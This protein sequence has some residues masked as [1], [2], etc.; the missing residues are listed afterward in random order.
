ML[1]IGITFLV[2][3]VTYYFISNRKYFSL[4]SPGLCLPV[5]GHVYKLMTEEGKKDPVMFLWNLYKKHQRN[6]MMHLRSFNLDLVF[7]GDFDTLKYI[8]NHPDCQ[9]RVIKAFEAPT[10]EDRMI[11]GKYIPGVIMSEGKIWADQRRFTLRTLRD[12]GF[13]KVGMEEMVLDEVNL[14]K[15]LIN[16]KKAE[17]IDFTNQFNL[18]ILNALWRI[19]VGDRF[20]YDNPKLI[21]IIERL[22]DMFKRI[23]KPENVITICFPWINKIF[24]TFLERDLSLKTNHDIMNLILESIKQHQ[25]TLDPNEPRDFTDKI[26][27]EIQQTTDATSSFYGNTGIE[28]LANTLYDLFLAGSETT[29]TTLTWASL[30]M[31]RYQ[32]I[33]EKV[34]EE[35]D[36]VVGRDKQP[37]MKDRANLPYTEAVLMEIQ[38]C[39]NI[40]PNGVQHV[41]HY[42]LTVN[43]LTIPA[44]TLIQPLFTEILKGEYWGDGM[45]FRPERFLDEEGNLKK[46]EHLI[47]F[48]IGKRQCLGETLARTE[49][50]IFFTNLLQQYKFYPEVEG[51]YPEENYCPGVTILPVPFKAK[52]VNRF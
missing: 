4:P 36:K 32:D 45:K 49:M 23:G 47:P 9:G 50:F 19:T 27:I 30:Y 28:N 8:F 29:S 14:F 38:R 20:D 42:D 13:G 40:V 48:S 1:L 11:K 24:P 46:D 17:P 22:T 37:T 39:A 35:L 16:S 43:G 18:P 31:I 15:A 25:D 3:L 7:V 2:L 21:S 41:C 34:Q 33:Q 26:L 6:G 5:V 44:Y 51:E 52:L 10:K 12:F